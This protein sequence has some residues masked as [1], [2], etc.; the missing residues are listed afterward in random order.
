M[1]EILKIATNIDHMK[2]PFNFNEQIIRDG[3]FSSWQKRGILIFAVATIC[4]VGIT[5]IFFLATAY[6]KHK[7][8][9]QIR[10]KPIIKM[11]DNQNLSGNIHVNVNKIVAT[12][13]AI[14]SEFTRLCSIEEQREAHKKA[15]EF[16][17]EHL[18]KIKAQIHFFSHTIKE[19]PSLS[20]VVIKEKLDS[21]VFW[22]QDSQSV[23]S[24]ILA[25]GKRDMDNIIIYGVASQFNGCEAPSRKTVHPGK[26]VEVYKTDSTQGP[27]AQLSFPPEQV[28]LINCGGN[29]GLNALCYLLSE[30][31]KAEVVHGYFTPSQEKGEIIIQQLRERGNLIE[32]PCVA[33]KPLGGEKVVHQFLVAAPAFGIYANNR[34]VQGKDQEEIQFLCALNAYRAQFEKCLDLAKNEKKP[35]IFKA[36]GVGMGVFENQATT[37]AKAFYQAALEYQKA[38]QEKEVTVLL[39]VHGRKAHEMASFLKL[40]PF[41]PNL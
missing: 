15:K 26:A 7:Q 36:V 6:F 23:M 19:T 16:L 35:V 32:Y 40:E 18:T 30:E 29:L 33:N 9:L 12:V 10:N 22:Q 27:E 4:T 24:N 5:I 39:Q 11:N 31:T 1:L 20:D 3:R 28:E 37:I 41:K 17:K 25:D 13:P 21:E 38:L 34:T 8:I 2:D 14:K